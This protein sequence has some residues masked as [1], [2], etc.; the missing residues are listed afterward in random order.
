L[1]PGSPRQ[2]RF[3]SGDF[4]HPQNSEE[5][6]DGLLAALLK[7]PSEKIE[8]ELSILI[9]H[10]KD[11]LNSPRLGPGQE[12]YEGFLVIQDAWEAVTNGM[13]NPEVFALFRQLPDRPLLFPWKQAVKGMVFFYQNRA[14]MAMDS[15]EKIPK[16]HPLSRLKALGLALAEK[17]Q[18]PI[19]PEVQAFLGKIREPNPAL[20][21]ALEQLY[22][23]QDAHLEQVFFVSL[24]AAIKALQKD[25]IPG[26]QALALWSIGPIWSEEW[27]E[28]QLL[29]LLGRLFG[30]REALRLLA[31]GL[32]PIDPEAAY[33]LWLQYVLQSL[34]GRFW[35]ETQGQAAIHIARKIFAGLPDFWHSHDKDQDFDDQR[36]SLRAQIKMEWDLHRFGDIP[37]TSRP[38]AAPEPITTVVKKHQDPQLDLF[39]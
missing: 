32:V 10:P 12:I 9:T 31:V 18:E 39:S 24:E 38:V 27:D 36:K 13:E 2:P 6:I 33:L 30:Q 7:A 23:A 26:A 25:F 17:N 15:W 5:R 14:N 16:A 3:L 35:T 28:G 29:N 22:D 20:V 8:S 1:V 4:S 37:E 34:R 21:D 11:L 19:P